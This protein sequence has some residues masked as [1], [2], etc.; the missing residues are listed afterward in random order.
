MPELT[1]L[2][3]SAFSVACSKGVV[4]IDPFLT[5]N[6]KAAITAERAEAD[7]I[8]VTH[9]HGDHLGDAISIAK[10]TG[11]CIVA[12]FELANHC[13]SQGA[14]VVDPHFGGTV[15]LPMGR[16]KLFPAVHSSSIDEGV[17]LGQAA[18]FLLEADGARIYHAGDTALFGDMRLVGEAGIDV[19]LLPIGGH[20]TMDIEDAVKAVKLLRP[21][22]VVPMHYNTFP[23][24]EADPLEFKRLVERETRSECEIL[25]PGERL[26]VEGRE[27]GEER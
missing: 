1:Y 23:L 6:P 21:V 26:T 14:K 22:T 4:L 2:G 25:K 8:L 11:A 13:A 18:S 5:G 17:N 19:A 3:H 10:R 27:E 20:Y 12:T 9:A 24:I 7:V 16:V 15:R